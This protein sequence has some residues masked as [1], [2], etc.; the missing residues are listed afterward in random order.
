MEIINSFKEDKLI[1][2]IGGKINPRFEI[3]R[4]LWLIQEM[5]DPY[6]IVDLG[7]MKK[8]Y[9][10]KLHPYGANMAIRRELLEIIKFPENLGRNGKSLLSGE[11]SWLFSKMSSMG[12]RLVYVPKMEVEHFIPKERLTK[13]WIL[14]R[15]YYQGVSNYHSCNRLID[16]IKR[17]LFTI[18]KLMYIY[19]NLLFIKDERKRF[20][21]KCR[22]SSVI[23]FYK[24]TSLKNNTIE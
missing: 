14:H 10:G 11:E 23:G 1:G 6:T 24:A 20:L 18:P 17:Y 15:Y 9:P 8:D 3:S 22:L 13:E 4:P 12:Y 16:K 5:E 21:H 19:V 7:E 2:G